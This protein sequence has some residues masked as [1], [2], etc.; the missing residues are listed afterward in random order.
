MMR[1]F[2]TILLAGCAQVYLPV[3][4]GDRLEIIGDPEDSAEAAESAPSLSVKT[5]EAEPEPVA[6]DE[7]PP[8]PG[9]F[10]PDKI[11]VSP[12][13]EEPEPEP[14]PGLSMEQT[15]VSYYTIN[16]LAIS[17]DGTTGMLGMSGG[18]SCEY[19]PD[20]AALS[21]ADFTNQICPDIPE[22]YDNFGRVMFLCG[23]VV[24]FWS[25]TWGSQNYVVPGLLDAQTR[26]DGFVTLENDGSCMVSRRGHDGSVSSVV[27]P[28]ELCETNPHIEI[29]EIDDIVYFANGDLYAVTDAD[30]R[31]VA[32]EVGDLVA[33]D[34]AHNS[35][36]VAWEAGSTLA[37][38]DHSGELKWRAEAAGGI[39]DLT[40][41]GDRGAVFALVYDDLSLPGSF[42]A[43]DAGRGEIWGEGI[44]WNGL[45]DFSIDAA[46]EKMLVQA[47]GSIYTYEIVVEE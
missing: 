38:L 28:D 37:A 4:E 3:I 35:L 11:D 43:Y 47:G 8:T 41:V 7:E 2:V 20:I 31:L 32:V 18:N 16:G 30:Y 26:G 6:A 12:P 25:P 5:P 39:Y 33:Y 34:P 46:G 36:L 40:P 42:V 1:L 44:A 24:G 22:E 15:G 9:V 29:N 27:L 45:I 23:E 10:F 13:V 21:G 14:L 19:N 17:R